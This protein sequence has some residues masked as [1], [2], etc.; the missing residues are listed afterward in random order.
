MRVTVQYL[1]QLKRALGKASEEV[2]TQ[3]GTS[4]AGLLRLLADRYDPAIQAMILDDVG[5]PRKS[6]LFFVG[7]EHADLAHSLT[8]G[9]V[10]TI[11]APM[12][13]G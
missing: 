4:L 6:L 9:D 10:V 13:G 12:S 7:D 8:D 11:L 2:E 5:D 1:T 3:A